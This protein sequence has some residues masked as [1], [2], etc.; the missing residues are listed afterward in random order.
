MAEM[1]D[2]PLKLALFY[3]LQWICGLAEVNLGFLSLLI[4]GPLTHYA[5]KSWQQERY[6]VYFKIDATP[7]V[8]LLLDIS[9]N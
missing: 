8:T 7:S 2:W 1:L 3:L 6:E 9:L 4:L 5:W